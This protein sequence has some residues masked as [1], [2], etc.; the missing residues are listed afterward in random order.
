MKA[1]MWIYHFVV[2]DVYLL[3]G[4]VVLLALVALLRGAL[5]PLDGVLALLGVL[6]V[7]TLSLVRRPE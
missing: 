4:T 6:A 5:G 1:V 7:L 2:G 3:W